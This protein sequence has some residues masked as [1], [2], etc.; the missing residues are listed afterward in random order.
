MACPEEQIITNNNQPDMDD[1]PGGDDG[2]AM[3]EEALSDASSERN[4]GM[5]RFTVV[6]VKEFHISAPILADKSL[7]SI[8]TKTCN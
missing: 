6:N 7:F 2:E 3:L 8:R 1:Y 4:W 5:D